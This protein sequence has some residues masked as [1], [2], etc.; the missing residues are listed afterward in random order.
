MG[1]VPALSHYM[2]PYPLPSVNDMITAGGEEYHEAS[3]RPLSQR[4]FP[5]FHIPG[6]HRS[7]PNVRV[8]C[9]PF[10]AAITPVDIR[11]GYNFQ[12]GS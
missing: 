5:R 9:L 4:V 11:N 7:R 10:N 1:R 8:D 6:I 12:G 3:H 2:N